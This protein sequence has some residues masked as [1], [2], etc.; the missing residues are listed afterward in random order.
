MRGVQTTKQANA[1]STDQH[2]RSSRADAPAA[3][4]RINQRNACA[5]SGASARPL[6][7]AVLFLLDKKPVCSCI[8]CFSLLEC[9]ANF[10]HKVL[11]CIMA[12]DAILGVR[13]RLM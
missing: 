2:T 13:S 5:K 9:L 11:Q 8:V 1:L 12:H 10:Y 6:E 3:S 4:L 7:E